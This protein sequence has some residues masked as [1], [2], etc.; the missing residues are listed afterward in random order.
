MNAVV[1]AATADHDDHN[2][3]DDNAGN[4]DV[5]DY[6]ENE[7]EDGGIDDN[8]A[9]NYDKDNNDSGSDDEELM[10]IMT[11]MNGESPRALNLE[12]S[13]YRQRGKIRNNHHRTGKPRLFHQ[14]IMVK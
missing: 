11:I 5:T 9:D 12:W 3:Q 1:T 2:D 14:L 10:A 8:D 13:D 7:D 4:D 6:D